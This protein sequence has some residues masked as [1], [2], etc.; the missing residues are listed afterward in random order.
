MLNSQELKELGWTIYRC[1][2]WRAQHRETGKKITAGTFP[3][4]INQVNSYV[5]MK[6]EPYGALFE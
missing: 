6:K 4:L 3:A 1:N 5:K 2:N